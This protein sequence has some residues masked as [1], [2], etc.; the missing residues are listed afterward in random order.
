[1]LTGDNN[2]I[3][4]RRGNAA[5]GASAGASTLSVNNTSTNAGADAGMVKVGAPIVVNES[6]LRWY[7]K[8]GTH[9]GLPNYTVIAPKPR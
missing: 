3:V 6:I 5:A 4:F 7:G 9:V 1:M 8:V 2:E